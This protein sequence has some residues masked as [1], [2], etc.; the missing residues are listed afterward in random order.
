MAILILAKKDA[1]EEFNVIHPP[2]VLGKYASDAAI[3]AALPGGGN[4]ELALVWLLQIVDLG[5]MV[6]LSR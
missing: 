6:W 2:D 5:C 3:D 1:T 4:G